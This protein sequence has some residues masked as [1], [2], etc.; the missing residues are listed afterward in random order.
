MQIDYAWFAVGRRLYLWHWNERDSEQSSHVLDLI[1]HAAGDIIGAYVVPAA[2]SSGSLFEGMNDIVNA[3]FNFVSHVLV[4]VTASHVALLA[5]EMGDPTRDSN[6][7]AYMERPFRITAVR[8]HTQQRVDLPV[9]STEGVRMNRVATSAHGRLLLAGDDGNIYEIASEPHDPRVFAIKSWFPGW[10]RPTRP[11]LRWASGERWTSSAWLRKESVNDAGDRVALIDIAFDD[12]RKLLHTL[13]VATSHHDRSQRATACT[14]LT[15]RCDGATRGSSLT[16]VCEVALPLDPP[17]ARAGS[18]SRIFAVPRCDSS[19]V[20]AVAVLANG[21]SHFVEEPERAGGGRS[22]RRGCAPL[23]LCAAE[24]GPRKSAPQPY[25]AGNEYESARGRTVLSSLYAVGGVFM[26]ALSC[27]TELMEW[28]Q[29]D[30]GKKWPAIEEKLR[31]QIEGLRDIKQ[32]SVAVGK[33]GALYLALGIDAESPLENQGERVMGARRSTRRSARRGVGYSLSRASRARADV[34]PYAHVKSVLCDV[35]SEVLEARQRGMVIAVTSVVAREQQ[36]SEWAVAVTATI[37]IRSIN[38]ARGVIDPSAKVVTLKPAFMGRDEAMGGMGGASEAA[39]CAVQELR[40]EAGVIVI[41]DKVKA[42]WHRGS[43][44]Y[45]DA[46]VTS[47]NI[48]GTFD[49]DFRTSAAEALEE[50][51]KKY[52]A[53]HSGSIDREELAQ[54]L[55]ERR[56][57]PR[58]DGKEITVEWVMET[59]D[60]DHSNELE[61]EEFDKMLIDIGDPVKNVSRKHIK[62]KGADPWSGP[63]S[64]GLGGHDVATRRKHSRADEPTVALVHALNEPNI[65]GV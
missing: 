31:P 22:V 27:D 35:F 3:G 30:V 13:S 20:C 11:M 45:K 25:R 8:Q 36:Q 19:A 51:F 61:K 48:N 1:E 23:A 41:G 39:L 64:R 56:P 34:D 55:K 33:D 5:I 57:L 54:L 58:I 29:T 17:L 26:T 52:D 65:Q 53:D 21:A 32:H 12:A 60:D 10:Y 63:S 14:V 4:V 7:A 2:R 44:E 49:L 15:Y 42:K 38:A 6:A 50:D 62:K 46:T 40:I 47:V 59:Y 24:A 43:G 9:L 18:G 28:L 37:E 16:L